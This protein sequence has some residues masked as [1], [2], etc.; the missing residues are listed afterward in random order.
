MGTAE[1]YF[2]APSNEYLVQRNDPP[3]GPICMSRTGLVS[4]RTEYSIDVWDVKAALVPPAFRHAEVWRYT[5]GLDPTLPKSLASRSNAVHGRDAARILQTNQNWTKDGS[6]TP[7]SA[8]VG[9]DAS[10]AIEGA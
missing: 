10:V 4:R 1:R 8:F 5:E 2:P 7:C 9:L 6:R 3:V